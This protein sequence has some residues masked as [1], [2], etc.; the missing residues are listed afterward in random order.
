M[1]SIEEVL[2]R[3]N[4]NR[5]YAQVVGNKGAAGIDKMSVDDLGPY[6]A[7]HGE[8]LLG[9][10]RKGTYKPGA[11]KRVEIPKPSGGVRLLGIPTVSDRMIQQAIGQQFINRT[12][13]KTRSTN[14]FARG[15]EKEFTGFF[16]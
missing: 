15:R 6:L 11:V 5:A 3:E 16:I 7:E 13:Y 9:K 10:I 4:L 2:N 8:E 12:E 1:I 14:I